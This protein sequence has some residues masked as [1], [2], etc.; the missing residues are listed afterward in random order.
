MLGG[1]GFRSAGETGYRRLVGNV[2][3][4]LQLSRALQHAD[5]SGVLCTALASRGGI[6]DRSPVMHEL[7]S[8]NN[9]PNAAPAVNTRFADEDAWPSCR[10][11]PGITAVA[12]SKIDDI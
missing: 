4:L 5:V 7:G 6:H 1:I 12:L 9:Y 3:Y 10:D 8:Y 2:R 11:C